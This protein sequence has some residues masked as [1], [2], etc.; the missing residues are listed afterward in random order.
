MVIIINKKKHCIL[1][2]GKRK[3]ITIP[4]EFIRNNY[5]KIQKISNLDIKKINIFIQQKNYRT[6]KLLKCHEELKKLRKKY[7]DDKKINN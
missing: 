3:I 7:K 4:D 1:Q 2:L 5:V 6:L